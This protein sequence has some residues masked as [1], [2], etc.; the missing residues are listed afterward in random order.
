[1]K[2]KVLITVAFIIVTPL[3]VSGLIFIPAC[4][5]LVFIL[6]WAVGKVIE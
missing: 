3:A 2:E 6:I 4:V 1:M 5:I